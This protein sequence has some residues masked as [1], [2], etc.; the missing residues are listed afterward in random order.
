MVTRR[1]VLVLFMEVG[2]EVKGKRNAPAHAGLT[3][4]EQEHKNEK[5]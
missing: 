1:I 4:R 2:G 5:S 3:Q